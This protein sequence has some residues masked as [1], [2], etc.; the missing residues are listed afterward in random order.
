MGRAVGKHQECLDGCGYPRG[1]AGDAISPLGRLP[2]LSQVVAA[3]FAPGRSAPEM[4]LS[5]LLRMTCH[6]CDHAMP[7]QLR[8][9]ALTV[10]GL[11]RET[12]QEGEAPAGPARGDRVARVPSSPR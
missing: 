5:V 11:T 8:P 9:L 12:P 6:H 7:E 4:R 1:L 3:M 10:S 2:S